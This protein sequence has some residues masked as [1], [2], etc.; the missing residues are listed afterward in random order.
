MNSF[1]NLFKGQLG[2]FLW[3]SINVSLP[4]SCSKNRMYFLVLFTALL[5]GT[6]AQDPILPNNNWLHYLGKK[7][8]LLDP[9]ITPILPFDLSKFELLSRR[10][11]VD[12]L[13]PDNGTLLQW[14]HLLGRKSVLLD[15]LINQLLPINPQWINL[16]GKRAANCIED[17]TLSINP[18]WINLL[19]KRYTSCIEDPLLSLNPLWINLLGKRAASWSDIVKAA[20]STIDNLK[21]IPFPSK[22]RITS[23]DSLLANIDWNKLQPLLSSKKRDIVYDPFSIFNP[24]ILSKKGFDQLSNPF[25]M[26]P[27]LIGRKKRREAIAAPNLNEAALQNGKGLL[28]QPLGKRQIDSI[29]K[30]IDTGFPWLNTVSPNWILSKKRRQSII[31]PLG[32]SIWGNGLHNPLTDVIASRRNLESIIAPTDSGIIPFNPNLILSKKRRQSIVSPTYVL[33]QPTGHYPLIDLI[34][35]KKRRQSIVS[36]IYILGQPT[37][38]S[39]TD[40]IASK[41]TT[42]S[43][44]QQSGTVFNGIIPFD[45]NLILSKKRDVVFDPLNINPFIISKKRDVIFDPSNTNPF[46]ISKKRDFVFDPLHPNVVS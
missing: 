22:K 39:L 18:Q 6:L 10:S 8:A 16:L 46:I 11:A 42:E 14:I 41:R 9:L 5:V 15:P 25:L 26:N 20:L 13:L 44:A 24:L 40:V 30:P 12:W 2:L 1:K 3:G 32:T 45:Y 21:E 7:N 34:L 33:G 28:G 29:I 23:L 38:H 36:P 19:G 35:S 37:Y 27:S 31:A 17:P 4:I 43:I